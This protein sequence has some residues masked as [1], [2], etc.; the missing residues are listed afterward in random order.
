[1]P[2]LHLIV[3]LPG[4]GKTT[5]AKRLEQEIHALRFSPDEWIHPLY[6]ADIAGEA[7]DAVR[8]PVEGVCWKVGSDA[9][10]LGVDVILDFGFWAK[11]E[12]DDYRARAAALGVETQIHYLPATKEELKERIELRNL[13]LTPGELYVSTDQ[14]EEWWAIFQ[15]PKDEELGLPTPNSS[16]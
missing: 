2:T 1:M 9:L 4:A 13:N 12:R 16:C 6:G 14:I 15:P 11:E 8:Y 3:G 7:L 5:Y 10:K